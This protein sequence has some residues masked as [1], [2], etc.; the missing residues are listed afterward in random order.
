MRAIGVR[1]FVIEEVQSYGKIVF[2]K[3]IDEKWLVRECIPQTSPLYPPLL[4]SSLN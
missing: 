3:N 2:I 4:I 1:I